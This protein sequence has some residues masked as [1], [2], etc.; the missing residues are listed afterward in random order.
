MPKFLSLD[1]IDKNGI[2]A[3]V[4]VQ[5]GTGRIIE[6]VGRGKQNEDGSFRNVE[7]VFD[8]DNPLLKRKVYGLLDTTAADLWAYIQQAKE[9][10]RTVSYRIESQRRNGVDRSSPISELNPTEQIRR[11]LAGI[12]GIFSHEAKTNPAEDPSNENPSALTQNLTPS[13]SP[14]GNAVSPEALVTALRDAVSAGLP[15]GVV[16]AI[17]AQA[18]ANGAPASTIQV[19]LQQPSAEGVDLN[20]YEMA[21]AAQAEQFALDHLIEIYTPAKSKDSVA[22]SDEML[23]QAASVA[24]TLLGLA[25]TVQAKYAS[26]PGPRRSTRSYKRALA[27]VIDA[28]DKRYPVPVGG[29]EQAQHEWSESVTA[30]ALERLYGLTQIAQGKTPLS[31]AERGEV[32]FIPP[33]TRRD[34]NEHI[35]RETSRNTEEEILGEM[36]LLKSVTEVAPFVPSAMPSDTDADFVMPDAAIINRLKNLCEKAEVTGDTKAISDWIERRLGV[37][38]ARK[39]HGP[40]LDAFCSHYENVGAEQVRV[41]VLQGV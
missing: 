2:R 20:S 29:N 23:S 7:I 8:P 32:N 3:E 24:I 22:V 12:D 35:E 13:A 28:V 17:A 9:D 38:T 18:L 37:R 6:I 40:V 11:I 25:D 34:S 14:T 36:S 31:E 1:G 27:L 39:V 5:T 33:E 16:D 4:T 19:H 10:G 21:R 30:E 26:L 41:E 15:Q